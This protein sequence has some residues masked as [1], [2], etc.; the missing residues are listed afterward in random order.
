M[1]HFL[2]LT[3]LI[4]ILSTCID[5]KSSQEIGQNNV[6]FNASLKK[7]QKDTLIIKWRGG[8]LDASC[9][10][11][12]IHPITKFS[13]GYFSDNKGICNLLKDGLSIS[14]HRG[15]GPG[16]TH[17]LEISIFRGKF[18]IKLYENNCTYIHK[19]K[20]FKQSLELNKSIF[21]IGDTLTGKLF[22]Q[23]ID[24][25]SIKNVVDTTTISGIFQLK[26]RNKDFNEDSLIVEDNYKKLL[27]T[28]SNPKPDSIT[29]LVIWK[30]G[31]TDLPVELAKFKNLEILKFGE[32]DFKNADLSILNKFNK[33]R[34]LTIRDCK[35]VEVPPSIFNLKNLEGLDLF[36][37]N[38]TSLPKE[39][40]K[41]NRIKELQLGGNLLKVIP[42]EILNL[43]ELQMLEISGSGYRND[44]EKLPADFFKKLSKL[45][46]FYPPDGM[47][48]S[49]YREYKS[50]EN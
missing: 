1:R 42:E 48:K 24:W 47:N 12:K 7:S 37:N 8:T 33:L 13:F 32:N 38:I 44:I 49:V 21:K 31:L 4:F 50:Q 27:V 20:M 25:D 22:Y 6:T 29:S 2:T 3:I 40:F 19:Y 18:D 23:A 34:F 28:L 16:R 35:L 36:N 41:L 39:L 30:C 10:D 17:S 26:I 9:V 5:K 43:R 11:G 45:T 46:E 14:T 15:Y